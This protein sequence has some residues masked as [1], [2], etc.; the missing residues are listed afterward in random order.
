M[1]FLGLVTIL[2]IFLPFRYSK[3]EP[4][5]LLWGFSGE[6]STILL[7][8]RLEASA[9]CTLLVTWQSLVSSKWEQA[10]STAVGA[11]LELWCVVNSVCSSEVGL[12]R[13]SADLL[14]YLAFVPLELKVSSCGS[15]SSS[16]VS[17]DSCSEDSCR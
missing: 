2:S 14:D 1:A 15:T 17:K 7:Q 10:V 9:S 12:S 6:V 4:L 13:L 16:L 5:G 11:S 3:T 8:L